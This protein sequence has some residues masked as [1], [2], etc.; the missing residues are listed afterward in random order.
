MQRRI[1][2][3]P[4]LLVCLA[5]YMLVLAIPV[6]AQ[7]TDE[8]M[9][10]WLDNPIVLYVFMVLGSI[11]SGLK[12][13]GVA[14]MEGSQTTIATYLSHIQEIV[15]TL[16]MNTIAFFSLVNSGTLNFVSA[17]LIGFAANSL[18]DLNPM[19]ARSTTLKPP[20]F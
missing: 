12:Q 10:V 13:W 2:L 8:Q 7:P 3:I 16:F 17:T 15:T 20:Q 5:L 14:K 6:M 9:K 19:G 18:S 11:V 4:V 1:V